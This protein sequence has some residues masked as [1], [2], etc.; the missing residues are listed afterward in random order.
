[1]SEEEARY[2]TSNDA[3]PTL[4]AEAEQEIIGL[5]A[6]IVPDN[7]YGMIVIKVR[8]GEITGLDAT[9]TWRRDGDS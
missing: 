8:N 9:H 3:R 7:W 2:N 6:P 1:M 4:T 5:V